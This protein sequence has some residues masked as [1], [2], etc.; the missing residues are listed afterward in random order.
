MHLLKQA[1]ACLET[2]ST[3]EGFLN[4][5]T[6]LPWFGHLVIHKNRQAPLPR[7]SQVWKCDG[8]DDCGDNSDEGAALTCRM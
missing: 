4:I 6:A 7:E 5:T 3:K 8:D 2:I 1:V